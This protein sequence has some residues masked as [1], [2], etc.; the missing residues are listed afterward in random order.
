ML[1]IQIKGRWGILRQ[2]KLL[3][4]IKFQLEPSKNPNFLFET[5]KVPAYCTLTKTNYRPITILPVLSKVFK[6]LV[7]TLKMFIIIMSLHIE[8]TMD[9]TQLSLV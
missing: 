2:T 5:G 8:I 7:H 6:K 9:A 3:D 4:M 1:N